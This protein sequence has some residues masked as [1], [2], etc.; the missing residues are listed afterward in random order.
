MKAL[1]VEFPIALDPQYAVWEAFAN[2]YWPAVYIADTEGRIRHHQFGEGG[3]DECERVI[4]QLLRDAGGDAVSDDLISVVPGGI[5]AQAE[6][7]TL[8]SPETYV[9][10]QQGGRNFA[11]P[12]GV[13]GDEARTYSVP[14]RCGSTRGRSRVTGRSRGARRS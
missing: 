13:T 6:W 8:G 9:G 1:N 12:E 11:S 10:Y 4:Q 5:E 2:R 7:G 3:Y 14:I